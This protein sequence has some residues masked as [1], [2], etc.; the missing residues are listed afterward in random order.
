MP[1]ILTHCI[2]FTI[3]STF[4]LS[5]S[6]LSFF[7]V[8]FLSLLLFTLHVGGNDT[9]PSSK[10][11][12]WVHSILTVLLPCHLYSAGSYL[13]SKTLYI[14]SQ[15][16]YHPSSLSMSRGGTFLENIYYQP[17]IFILAWYYQMFMIKFILLQK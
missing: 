7:V 4:S 16:C 15:A 8:C 9:P 17:R 6:V 2:T 12:P 3:S 10:P 1:N 11:L 14:S 13:L 5:N